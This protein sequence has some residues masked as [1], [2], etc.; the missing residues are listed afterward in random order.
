[1]SF[2]A[3]KIGPEGSIPDLVFLIPSNTEVLIR[4]LSLTAYIDQY[5]RSNMPIMMTAYKCESPNYISG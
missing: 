2:Y 4:G 5:L 1:M 3:D